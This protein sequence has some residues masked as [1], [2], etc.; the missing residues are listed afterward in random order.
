MINDITKNTENRM[1]K[2]IESLKNEL[3]KLRTGR[4]HPSIL[5]HVS[6]SYY[7]NPTP[8]NQVASVTIEGPRM[9][10]VSPWE[11]SLVV[12]V[13]KAI[14]KADLGLNPVG[15][16]DVIRVPMPALTEERRREILKLVRDEGEKAKVSI[17]NIRRDANNDVKEL[18][19]EKEITE[20]DERRAQNDVQKLT[21]K[22][23][24]NVDEILSVKE[25]DVM[26][27]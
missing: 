10:L 20:D 17:R 11:K 2:S 6:V 27:I 9:L 3:T 7:G 14:R 22:F 21:D 24:A 13:E 4:A 23:V 16:G 8:L 12:D 25:T 5:E 15:S 19:K 26:E 1:L 18:L